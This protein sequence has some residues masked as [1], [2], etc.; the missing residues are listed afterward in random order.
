MNKYTKIISLLLAA[1]MVFGS[2][3]ALFSCG[4]NGDD[5][6]PT[7]TP[8]PVTY[9]VNV[10]DAFGAAPEGFTV[11][12]LY[13][14]G[15]YVEQQR[16]DSNGTATFSKVPHSYTFKIIFAKENRYTYDESLATLSATATEAN[17]TVYNFAGNKTQ[18]SVP[19][20]NHADADGD[21]RCDYCFMDTHC[22]GFVDEN[23]DARCDICLTKVP[24]S[25]FADADADGICDKCGVADHCVAFVDENGDARCDNCD[26]P[27]PCCAYVDEDENGKCDVCMIANHCAVHVKEEGEKRC[28]ACRMLIPC[29]Y[30]VD[31]N[32]DATCDD[33]GATVH[34]LELADT[35]LNGKCDNCNGTV[36]CTVHRNPSVSDDVDDRLCDIC[37]T[38]VPCD[39]YV[40]ENGD[41]KC[42]TCGAQ[43]HCP[44]YTDENGDRLCDICAEPDYE[45][46]GRVDYNATEL[47]EGATRVE[48]D[49][50]ELTY[51]I[52]TPTRAGTYKFSYEIDGEA[53]FGNFGMPN[54]VQ[55]DTL[56]D[57]TDGVF[58]ANVTAGSIGNDL[59]G[60][61][62]MVIG[63]ASP[64]AK[65]AIIKIERIGDAV[66]AIPD[67]E[68]QP[69]PDIQKYHSPLNS[70]YVDIDLTNPD[71]KVVFN[72]ND[73]YYHYGTANGPL[74][75]VKISV[76]GNSSVPG[77][78]LPS[79]TTICENDRMGKYFYEGDTLVSKE[80]YNYLISV[81][82]ELSGSNGMR[83]LDKKMEMVIKNT[84]DQKGW[85]M[86]EGG[87]SIFGDDADRVVAENAWLFA[88]CYEVK[89]T[90]GTE[91][92]P[93][94]IESTREAEPTPSTDAVV[95]PVL[96]VNVNGTV[97]AFLGGE[98][99]ELTFTD[100]SGVTVVYK[101]T[102]YT[103]NA[104]GVITL[105]VSAGDT[106]T[107][108][109]DS[110]RLVTLTAK[111]V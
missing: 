61:L 23:G 40:D 65:T 80:T 54:F 49:R 15:E 101:G 97:Y 29:T 38:I 93:V 3:L 79:F 7:P 33:C 36:H 58:T 25:V 60:T 98:D 84:G 43:A 95:A 39:S 52:F 77:L 45:T 88:C 66:E 106:L 69:D 75:L 5:N 99:A 6:P 104:N 82:D 94:E 21:Y 47:S 11:V 2:A 91:S 42:D 67:V 1:V 83:P 63:I 90:Y 62:K 105:T 64:T 41:N 76:G 55:K 14:N 32:G 46:N 18:I 50:P 59:G 53:V 110:E 68:I 34:C 72:E 17:I 27:V 108:T 74:V 111:A 24:C 87:L 109:A 107:I 92:S 56:T 81:Y 85:W 102:E 20:I 44:G 48:I 35:D 100:A 73:G 4:D 9:K 96:A 70:S 28:S 8:T 37:G 13:K 16:T 86:L 89:N 19:C 12:E 57:V 78:I 10:T 71:V 30:Y 51:F 26:E 22:P 103:A 31:E